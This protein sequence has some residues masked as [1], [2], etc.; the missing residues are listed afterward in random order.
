MN[1]TLKTYNREVHIFY[2]N[3]ENVFEYLTSKYSIKNIY[4]KYIGT[5]NFTIEVI[6]HTDRSGSE[7][8]NITLSK[9]RAN[10]VK[11]YLKSLGIMEERIST[12]YFG[13]K[14][15]KI[16]TKDGIKEKS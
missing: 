15:P 8:Y 6:G 7:Q 16:I 1:K 2:E 11:K 10:S 12:F 9:L 4:D 5:N 14:K 13:E 3:A